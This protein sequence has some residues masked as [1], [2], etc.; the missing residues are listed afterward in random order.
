MNLS[1]RRRATLLALVS[2]GVLQLVV[3]PLAAATTNYPSK[4]VRLIVPFPPGSATDLLA[5]F[6][7]AKLAQELGQPFVIENRPGAGGNIG[8]RAVAEAKPDGYTLGM[9]VFG[10]HAI[11]PHLFEDMPFDSI[12]AFQPI[13]TLATAIQVL[14]V[15]PSVKADTVKELID[16]ARARPG[17]LNF[18]SPGNGSTGQLAASLLENSADIKFTNVPFQGASAARLS[19]L[20]GDTQLSFELVTTAVPHIRTGKLKALAVTGTTR[21]AVLP[22]VPTMIEAGLPG[23]EVTT[24]M[25]IVGPAGVP[26]SVVYRLNTSINA[27]LERPETIKALDEIGTTAAPETPE[28][29]RERMLRDRAK[30]GKLIRQAGTKLD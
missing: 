19:L 18:A 7:G 16:Y 4:P 20:G 8:S 14:V 28:A 23:F 10:V 11:N 21:S 22:E 12:S 25:S 9:G 15:S 24:W 26:E 29:L 5:R 3:Q 13:G 17:E 6:M 27:I 1:P 30:W 2:A